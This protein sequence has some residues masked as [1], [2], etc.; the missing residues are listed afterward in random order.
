MGHLHHGSAIVQVKDTAE[1]SGSRNESGEW[2]Q[3][4]F[5]IV[6]MQIVDVFGQHV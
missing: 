1:I 5:G 2:I 6:L 4:H 3:D